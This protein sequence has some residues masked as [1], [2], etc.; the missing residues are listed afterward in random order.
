MKPAA[1]RWCSTSWPKATA[2]SAKTPTT[3]R[4]QLRALP[5]EVGDPVHAR[6]TVPEFKVDALNIQSHPVRMRRMSRREY[7][8]E[9]SLACALD[10][11][12]RALVAAD[13]PRAARSARCASPTSPA[14][15]AARPTD[16]LTKRLRDLEAD[17]VVDRRELAPPAAAVVYELTELGRGLERP[18]IELAR[19]GMELQKAERRRR[20]GAV[21]AAERAAGDPAPAGR[22]QLRR[23]ACAARARSYALRARDGWIAASPRRDRRP[24]PDPLR[25]PDRGHGGGR[26]RPGR[27]CRGS[28]SKGTRGAARRAAGDGRRPRAPARR[29]RR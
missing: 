25:V 27:R 23:S 16:V 14:P 22:R 28:R 5:G 18:M 7:G 4:T 2:R 10:S 15:S 26:R 12:R 17:G 21:L 29:K 1:L 3:A 13:R 24:R 19:W 20:A 9:C 8:Q 6:R 11:D